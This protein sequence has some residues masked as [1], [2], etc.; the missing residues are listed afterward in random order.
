[1]TKRGHPGRLTKL[2]KKEKDKRET[3]RKRTHRS[4][5]IWA[6]GVIVK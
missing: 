1:M 4:A 3:K 2:T 6:K 5:K